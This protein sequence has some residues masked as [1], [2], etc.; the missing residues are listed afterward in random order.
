[1]EYAPREY[2]SS[3]LRNKG[4]NYV[5]HLNRA[6]AFD[7]Q[8]VVFW[9]A[10]SSYLPRGGRVLDFGCGVGRFAPMIA[11]VV[12][13]YDGVDLTK[14]ALK[15]A[16]KIE[17][18][19][20]THL[21]EDK[22]PFES[23]SFDGA[24]AITVIQHIVTDTDFALW[25]SEL[26]R[27][28]KG[29]GFFIGIETPQPAKRIVPGAHMRWRTP[30]IIAEAMGAAVEESHFLTAEFENSHYCFRAKL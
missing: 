9:E 18:A 14:D 29:G 21:P 7:K 13:N 23:D 19:T 20:F 1:M 17:N 22:L 4:K 30:E 8:A 6:H 3:R 25:T 5:A 16:P 27:V 12:D 10:L 2:W 11:N 26:A 24:I 15:F 28:L